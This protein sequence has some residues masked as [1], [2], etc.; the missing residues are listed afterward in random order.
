MNATG[1][2]EP[3]GD[4][5]PTDGIET[6]HGRTGSVHVP[7]LLAE[8]VRSIAQI[9]PAT[10]VDGTFGGGGHSLG[11]LNACDTDPDWP[12]TR[13]VAL[14]RDPNV[15]E[16]HQQPSTDQTSL[17]PRIEL[18]LG[19]Y[20][21]VGKALEAA[22]L[23]VAQAM[24]L[25]LGLS[26]DQLADRGRGFSFT[27]DGPLDLRFDPESGVSAAQW[28]A[29]HDEATI[30]DAIYQFG[31]E[32]KSRR[33]A[34]AIVQ[35]ARQRDPVRTV[36]QLVEICRRCVP[37]SRNHDIHPATRT[38]QALRIAVNDELGILSR[39]LAK[40]PEW[41]CENGRLAVISFHSLEDRLVKQAFR[42]DPRWQ[43]LHKKPV[44]PSDAEILE[45]PRSRSAKLRVAQRVAQ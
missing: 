11:C 22:E 28:L 2:S 39:T 18:F 27:A 35:S 36:E 13:V 20:E 5:E 32:R 1:A 41:L 31:E 25:D 24:I 45:N 33:I 38:F 4:R 26:S 6:G 40:A 12:A 44:R 37:R 8:T 43:P 21:K 17:D 19:S 3:T 15:F 16:R 14:D 30:A 29:R 9:R 10:I 23:D 42:D 7:V 34:R